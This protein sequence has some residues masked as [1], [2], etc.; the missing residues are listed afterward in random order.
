M[1]TKDKILMAALD[2][3]SQRGYDSV[4]MEEIAN[5]VG[6][7][8]PSLYKHYKNKRD[9]WDSLIDW[10]RNIYYSKSVS[11]GFDLGT[12]VVSEI[13]RDKIEFIIREIKKQ[14]ITLMTEPTL[15]KCRRLFTLEQFKSKEAARELS[16]RS[17]DSLKQFHTN[18]AKMFL[19]AGLIKECDP[20]IFALQ[21]MSPINVMI[22]VL[23]RQ[24]EREEEMMELLDRHIRSFINDHKI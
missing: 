1:S 17:Y 12:V 11:N 4:T 6:I 14:V 15:V 24:P 8:A 13:D 21:F 19:K 3:F 2:L 7:K 16:D 10:Q 23:D 22:N 9:I 5:A 18:I 20:E